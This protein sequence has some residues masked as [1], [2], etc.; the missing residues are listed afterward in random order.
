MKIITYPNGVLREE[1]KEVLF[2]LDNTLLPDLAQTLNESGGVG[3]AA[4]QIGINIQIFLIKVIVGIGKID[5]KYYINPKLLNFNGRYSSREMCLSCPGEIVEVIRHDKVEVEY[6]DENGEKHKE[7]IKGYHSTVWQ[8]E[9][10]HLQSKLIID[11][12]KKD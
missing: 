6:L 7:W 12:R 9:F 4:P 11:Y 10:D 5:Y 8:H 3:L 1:N 2:P